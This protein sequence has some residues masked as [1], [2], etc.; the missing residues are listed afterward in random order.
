MVWKRISYG[1]TKATAD[2]VAKRMKKE[3]EEVKITHTK[4]GWTVLIKAPSFGRK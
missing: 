2:E 1:S 3:G 4:I